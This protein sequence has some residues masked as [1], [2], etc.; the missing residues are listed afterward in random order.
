M[1]DIRYFLAMSQTLN[2]TKAAEICNVTQP[3]L[4]RAIRKLEDELGGLLFSREP[5]N[6]HM[7]DL[8]R[9]IEPHLAEIMGHAG[10]AKRRATRFLKLEKANFALGIMCTIAPVQFVSFLDRF[11]ADNP[12]IEITLLEA[13][14]DRLCDLLAKGEMDVALMA[15]PDGFPA[16]LQA[17]KLYSERFV[18]ACSAG[19][20]FA[21]ENEIR[22]AELDG[23]FYLKRIN[24]E[25]YDVL[26]GL[27]REHGA[28]LMKSYQCEREDW[29]LR[30][31]LPG[32]GSA[33]CPNI[34]PPSRLSLVAPYLLRSS[35]MS[36]WLRSPAVAG[37]HRSRLSYRRCGVIP[38]RRL[39]LPSISGNPLPPRDARTMGAM[40]EA[41]RADNLAAFH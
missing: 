28:S 20:R 29:I 39:Q 7:T 1:Q 38:G 11:G 22:M 9:L 30:W 4:T 8:G 32:W 12:G 23:E 27:C 15:R 3:A 17:S 2:F 40:S 41:Y 36:A 14:P 35:A 5:N 19:H 6:T 21:M 26:D 31:S 37:H 34:Q 18:I 16:P 24:C 10:E 33:S 13:V 25:F